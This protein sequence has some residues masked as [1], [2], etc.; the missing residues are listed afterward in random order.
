MSQFQVWMEKLCVGTLHTSQVYSQVDALRSLHIATNTSLNI[1]PL[2]AKYLVHVCVC[3]YVCVCMCV[4]ACVCVHVYVHVS[5]RACV[6]A[7]V[8]NQK[9]CYQMWEWHHCRTALTCHSAGAL[10]YLLKVSFWETGSG[11]LPRVG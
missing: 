5:V 8:E 9:Q 10:L 4:C 6:Y 11:Y 3:V 1:V 2:G 7:F